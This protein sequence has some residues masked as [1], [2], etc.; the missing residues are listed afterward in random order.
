MITTFKSS[1]KAITFQ[2]NKTGL[3]GT[4]FRK[5]NKAMIGAER[6]GSTSKLVLCFDM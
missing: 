3:F 2:I 5:A 1:I 6:L 4:P